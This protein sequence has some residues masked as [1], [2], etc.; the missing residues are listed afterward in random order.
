MAEPEDTIEV[1]MKVPCAIELPGTYPWVK[2]IRDI[3]FGICV[4]V[5]LSV[6]SFSFQVSEDIIEECKTA[7]DTDETFM[8]EVTSTKCICASMDKSQKSGQ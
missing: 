2:S 3:I 6:W 7:C 1:S 5:V 4:A 8:A